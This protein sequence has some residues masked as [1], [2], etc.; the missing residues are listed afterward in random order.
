MGVPSHFDG[1]RVLG[2]LVVFALALLYYFFR[3]NAEQ[4]LADAND[5][6]KPNNY[7]SGAEEVRIFVSKFSTHEDASLARVRIGMC[8]IR[9]DIESLPNPI[10]ALKTAERSCP[11]SL[12]SRPGI[13]AR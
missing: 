4:L 13:G 7:E 6:Y 8:K 11:H 1:G 12:K 5:A 10:E 2:L 9:K 3:G